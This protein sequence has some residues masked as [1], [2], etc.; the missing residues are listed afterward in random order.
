MAPSTEI[1]IVEI[2]GSSLK[3]GLDGSS[4][5]ASKQALLFLSDK[6]WLP[7][8]RLRG[9]QHGEQRSSGSP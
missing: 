4:K 5:Q 7:W 3:D 2:M 8:L 9:D 1:E 6:S